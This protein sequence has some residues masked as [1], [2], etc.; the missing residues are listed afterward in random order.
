MQSYREIQ[1]GTDACGGWQSHLVVVEDLQLE[2]LLL[3]G[4]DLSLTVHP[5]LRSCQLLHKI[6]QQDWLTISHRAE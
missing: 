2:V 5:P 1:A 3:A 6:L 4:R